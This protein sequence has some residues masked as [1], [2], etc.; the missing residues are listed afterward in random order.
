MKRKN[1]LNRVGES[2]KPFKIAVRSELAPALI[3]LA[4]L[5]VCAT[6]QE[7]T[8]D[9]WFDKGYELFHQESFEE[10]IDSF[11]NSIEIDPQHFDSWLYKGA[12]LNMLA[13]K[14]YGQNRIE[15][16]EE[17]LRAYDKAIEI[18]PN[19]ASAWVFK[20]DALDNMAWSTDDP[21]RF[22]QSLQAFD[23]A[24][25]LDPKDAGAWHA[26]GVT[27]IHFAQ[28]KEGRAGSRTE[29]VEGMLNEALAA[30]NKAIE[31]DP[32]T[33]G[34]LENRAGLLET[35]GKHDEALESANSTQDLA[36][37]WYNRAVVLRN[38]GKFDEALDAYDK[39][40][41]LD[42]KDAYARIDKGIT[43]LVMGKF[44][45][46]LSAFDEALAIEPNSSNLWREKGLVLSRMGMFNESLKAYEASLRIDPS[47]PSALAGRGFTLS[48][49]G[50]YDEALQAFDK[51]IEIDPAYLDIAGVWFAKGDALDKLG[52]HDEA[53]AAYESALLA[54]DRELERN[55]GV[56]KF[57]AS[58]GEALNA[59]GRQ[60]E[61]DDA[62]ARAEELGYKVQNKADAETSSTPK[63]LAIT[64]V[65]A[66]DE[67]E[68]VVVTNSRT[69]AQSLN[70]WTLD[71]SDGKNG[72]R[73]QSI[74]LPDL[75]L[76]PDERIN[77]HLGKGESNE[78][79]IF[80]NSAIALN[81]TAGN[82]TLKDEAGKDVASFGYRVEPDGSITGIMT[83]EGEFSYPPS[84]SSEVKMA[85]REAGS[86]PYVAERTE[87]EPEAAR[88]NASSASATVQEDTADNSA[89]GWIDKGN[90]LAEQG[91]YEE[92]VKALDNATR[93]SPQDKHIWMSRGLILAAHMGRYNESIEAYERAIQI[94]PEDADAWFGKGVALNKTGRYEE[95]IKS[96][97]RATELDP[98]SVAAWKVKGDALKALCRNSEAETAFVN[99]RE[100]GYIG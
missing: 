38:E 71:V 74:T 92:A 41:E 65:K 79:D 46:S 33:P 28:H 56:A 44:N 20:G 31:I 26:K 50:R 99:A 1:L 77:V 53:I 70:G 5:C 81:D 94:D 4:M 2:G 7:N 89:Y 14:F 23:K 25:E 39:A 10:A 48:Q 37:V 59:L 91:S 63:M 97:D 75:T 32:E 67:D 45:E 80:L 35:M 72:G 51:V 64:S 47:N 30:I 93:L 90:A 19:N 17:S 18:N 22:N 73:I 78:T 11:N 6:A 54:Y 69:A 34:A 40:I 66:A 16:F 57:W 36:K 13:F 96:L 8:A 52:R 42:P 29:E 100:L 85:V 87:Y 15:T 83:A 62:Y 55:P 58:K 12:A 68:F 27:L 60:A 3:A 43:F 95:A 82:I 84:G 24:L 98:K 86:G 61:A 88:L 21:S 76:G 49:M 9:Y